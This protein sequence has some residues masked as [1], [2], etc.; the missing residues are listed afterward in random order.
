MA[1]DYQH[2]RTVEWKRKGVP[3]ASMR[4]D[5]TAS[6][7]GLMTVFELRR[8]D[9]PK[10]LAAIEHGEDDPGSASM[11]SYSGSLDN[12]AEEAQGGTV[13]LP[14]M[15][16]LELFGFSRRTDSALSRMDV[17]LSDHAL[18]TT[19]EIADAE[20]DEILTIVSI[21]SQGNASIDPESAACSSSRRARL[22]IR[23]VSAVCTNQSLTWAISSQPLN[24]ATVKMAASGFSQ[25]PVFREAIDDTPRGLEGE[26]TW[27]SIAFAYAR[28]LGQNPEPLVRDAMRAARIVD[29]NA[30]IL[31]QIETIR[32]HGHLFVRISV[33]NEEQYRVLTAHDLTSQ[34]GKMTRPMSLLEDIEQ[35][36]RSEID[37]L[38][39]DFKSH[40]P[41]S[42]S[43]RENGADGLTFGDYLRVFDEHFT[44]FQ[45]PIPKEELLSRLEQVRGI[46]NKVMHFSPDP[47]RVDDL[48]PIEE[49]AQ[50]LRLC[51]MSV[52]L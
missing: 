6:L 46:R 38:G 15:N 26:I 22:N 47:L 35:C 19:P 17:W 4:I 49:L 45:L 21:A 30:D 3:R 29:G 48:R 42:R 10:R 18:S 8:N 52:R 24:S 7:R 9:I 11:P 16:F 32:R 34:F 40:L 33:D 14:L 28:H 43:A 37:R 39:D 36:L 27:E 51:T 41:T 23:R 25:L 20:I 1:E 50:I 2:S 13:T 5:L 31:D 44:E 12:L